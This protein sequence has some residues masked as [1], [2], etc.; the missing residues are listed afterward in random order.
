MT[1]DGFEPQPDPQKRVS[2]SA[3]RKMLGMIAKNYSDEDITE[4][5]DC[6]YGIAGEAFERYQE[7]VGNQKDIIASWD[8]FDDMG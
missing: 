6:L 5:L 7:D 2:T 1:A 8:D 4:I 3:A